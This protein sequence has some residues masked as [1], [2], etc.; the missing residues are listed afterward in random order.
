MSDIFDKSSES[1]IRFAHSA[2]QTESTSM[3]VGC[4]KHYTEI[5]VKNSNK[6]KFN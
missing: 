1:Q 2:K 6:S 3:A 4:S 5:T